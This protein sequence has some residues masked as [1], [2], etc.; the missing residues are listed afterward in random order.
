M[1]QNANEFF[2]IIEKAQP[3]KRE[4]ALKEGNISLQL[5]QKNKTTPRDCS[6]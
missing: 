2:F 4:G 5:Q 1:M 3:P 6:T